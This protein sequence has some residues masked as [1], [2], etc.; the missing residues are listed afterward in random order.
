MLCDI[1]LFNAR[2]EGYEL[3]AG[4]LFLFTIIREQLLFYKYILMLSY[5]RN[6]EKWRI[7]MFN[8][9]IVLK[10]LVSVIND[11]SAEM[12]KI[13]AAGTSRSELMSTLKV[14]GADMTYFGQAPAANVPMPCK[15]V[16]P[17]KP[18][19]PQAPKAAVP[20]AAPQPITHRPVPTSAPKKEITIFTDGS[21]KDGAYGWAYAIYDGD[22]LT[23]KANG[24]GDEP[25]LVKTRNVAGELKAVMAAMVW[26]K[27]HLSGSDKVTVV[28]DYE[29]VE[30]WVLGT[31]KAK[32]DITQAYVKFMEPFRG[33]ITFKK[34]RAHTGVE[35]NE[36]AD[37]LAKEA[38]A[39]VL[40]SKAATEVKE[41]APVEELT[42]DDLPPVPQEEPAPVAPAEESS[43]TA[44]MTTSEFNSEE[45]D[46]KQRFMD[47]MAAAFADVM[48]SSEAE[49]F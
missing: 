17:V 43:P 35:G 20:K 47:N 31:W 13:E 21:F 27:K 3:A 19:A 24:G 5:R 26:C 44:K 41:E 42:L 33:N 32:N 38:V 4:A 34:V 48:N 25:E 39:A 1:S 28:Y 45:V 16:R 8:N 36:L 23:Q 49:D 29:G 40:S 15:T 12:R 9:I 30:N 2:E 46:G 6:G 7:V 11:C 18:V 37:K 22:K 10:G 14:L